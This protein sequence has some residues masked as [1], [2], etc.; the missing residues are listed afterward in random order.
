MI[1]SLFGSRCRVYTGPIQ[2]LPKTEY[3]IANRLFGSEVSLLASS[4]PRI[5][6]K[7]KL[8]SE[9]ELGWPG[10]VAVQT[11]LTAWVGQRA[12]WMK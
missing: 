6:K 5:S 11:K 7:Q 1:D 2:S 8:L 3:V 4:V 12:Q 10:T 9:N